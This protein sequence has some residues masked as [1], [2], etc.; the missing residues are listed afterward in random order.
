VG[1]GATART[2][3]SVVSF[4]CLQIFGIIDHLLSI[5]ATLALASD[6]IDLKHDG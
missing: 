6:N 1:A 4:F 2:A 3:L 5:S